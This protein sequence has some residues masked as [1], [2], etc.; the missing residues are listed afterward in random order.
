MIAFSMSSARNMLEW[1]IATIFWIDLGLNFITGYVDSNQQLVM[2]LK[3]IRV[4]Y[5][6]TWFIFDFVAT[7]PFETIVNQ[8]GA[9]LGKSA[10]IFQLSR[11]PRVFRL[12]KIMKFLENIRG[13]NIWRILRLFLLFFMVSHWVGCIFY[14]ITSSDVHSD[15][16]PSFSSFELKTD[17]ITLFSSI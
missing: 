9:E 15:N 13:A 17:I 12:G 5:L 2:D 14:L 16:V 6:K 3:K 4:H 7:L 8:F 1:L 10:R 11:F